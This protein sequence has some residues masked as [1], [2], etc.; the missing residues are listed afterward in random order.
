MPSPAD[1]ASDSPASSARARVVITG[2]GSVSGLGLGAAA[3]WDGLCAGRTAIGPITALDAS[4]FRSQLAAQVPELAVKDFVPKHYRKATKVMARDI[5]L[6]VVAAKLAVDDAGLVTRGSDLSA[7][8]ESAGASMTYRPSRMGCNIGA[9]LIAADSQEMATAMATSTEGDAGEKFSLSRWGEVGMD[10]LTP[11]WLLKYLPNMLACHVTI[12]HGAEGPSNT[13]TCSEASG[14]LTVGESMRIIERGAADLCFA[15]SAESKLNPMGMLR[16][17]LVG[18]LA[19]V[20]PEADPAGVV[21]PFD[22]DSPGGILGE[23]GGIVVLENAETAKARGAKVYAEVVGFGG[24]QSDAFYRLQPG[25][26]FDEGFA[27]AIENAL[28][29]AGIGP[30]QV[31]VIV[32]Q[33]SGVPG[34]DRAELGALRAVFGERLES[35]PMLTIQPSVGNC[36]AGAGGLQVVA[37]ALAIKHQRLPARIH[38]GKPAAGVQ[39]GASCARDARV[40]Y[41]LLTSGSL[42]GQNAAVVLKSC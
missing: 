10:N 18:R 30:E 28:N 3:L 35:V 17:D 20:G 42:G 4:G 14:L 5:E 25:E 40:E 26:D 19:H 23:G 39:A 41:A 32:P 11:L 7:S 13:I 33:G 12:I 6:A 2:L 8:E 21:R 27:A 16:L 15:G 22:P 37:A 29:D 9:G 36:V 1:R 38:A 24:G 31:S 34:M